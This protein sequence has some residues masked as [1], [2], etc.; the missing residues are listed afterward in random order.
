MRQ[1]TCIS[2][3]KILPCCS[4]EL[5]LPRLQVSRLFRID[6]LTEEELL[7]EIH[8][9]AFKGKSKAV[10][11]KEFQAMTQAPGIPIRQFVG[12]PRA[13]QSI[14]TSPYNAPGATRRAAMPKK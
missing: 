4:T 14:A 5:Q 6:R 7:T 1:A 12:Q 2:H 11:Q 10:H 3:D 13:K 9:T 8:L